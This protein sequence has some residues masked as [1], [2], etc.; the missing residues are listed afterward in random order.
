MK[1]LKSI[2]SKKILYIFTLC[3]IVFLP[4]L[5]QL[6][7]Y[8]VKWNFIKNYDSINPVYIFCFCIPFLIYV[9]IKNLVKTKR[10]LDIFDYLFYALVIGG[11]IVSLLAMDKEISFLGKAYRHEGFISLLSY[12]LLFINWKIEGNK[13]DIKKILNVIIIMTI[14]NS[15]YALLQIYSPLKWILRFTPDKQMAS[16]MCGN[17]NFFGSLMVTT[18]GI[19]T[20]KYLTEE[21]NTKINIVLIIL[22]FISLINSQSTGPFLTYIITIIFLIVYLYIKKTM[23]VKKIMYLLIILLSTYVSLF[24]VNK[25][26]FNIK[27]CEMC[28]FTAYL[29]GNEV[30]IDNNGVSYTITNGRLENWKKSLNIAK[31]NLIT[32]VGYDNFYI[33]YYEGVNLTQVRFVSMDGVLK[34]VPVYT[35]IL[36]N[37]HNVYIHTLVTSGLIG[38]IPYLIICLL[39]FIKGLK[40]KDNLIIILLGGFVAYS[41]QAFA[42]ISVIHVAPIYYI[43]MGLMLIK[44]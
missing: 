7:F 25:Y 38:T 23:N 32:G 31:K 6:S 35:E 28:D 27:K 36:D 15:I 5:K 40:T 11:I 8:F 21:K 43:I 19:I 10:K 14:I 16:G 4:I 17:P 1:I 41:I 44:E 3:I 22:F 29:T 9:Y 34:A 12:Y 30:S 26:I 13:Q 18:L 33:A 37:A 20:V 39:V 42:N 24:L 2:T